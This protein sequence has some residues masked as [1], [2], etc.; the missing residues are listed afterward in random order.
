MKKIIETIIFLASVVFTGCSSLGVA[1][2]GAKYFDGKKKEDLVKYFKYEGE[3]FKSDSEYDEVLYFTNLV[4]TMYVDKTTIEK[5]K[6]KRSQEIAKLEFYTLSDGCQ[7]WTD[8]TNFN[9]FGIDITRKSYA[10]DGVLNNNAQ[11]KQGINNY[12]T[13]V[14]Q[15]NAIENTVPNQ[16]RIKKLVESTAIG[17]SFYLWEIRNFT[18]GQ[19][20]DNYHNEYKGTATDYSI[21][22]VDVYEDSKSSTETH[23]VYI[24][25]DRTKSYTDEK[26][27][28]LSKEQ[29]FAT[30]KSYLVKG[31]ESRKKDKGVSLT[32][33][34]KDGVVVKIDSAE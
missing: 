25:D 30:E 15:L 33:Y 12:Y 4:R 6:N 28:N 20:M 29:A 14:Q 31:F 18:F 7:Y 32:A 13:I 3:S 19:Y 22:K 23:T 21:I 9:Y 11:I 5:F 8:M 27:N 16:Q 2:S 26:G 1:T 10:H 34:I 24:F 17:K